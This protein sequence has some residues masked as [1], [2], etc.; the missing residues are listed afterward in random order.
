M[1][2]I[3][4][5][6]GNFETHES[7]KLKRLD[8]VSVPN[9][10]LDI[11]YRTLIDHPDGAA[12]FGA[13][14]VIIEVAST[15]KPRGSLMDGGLGLTA[16]HLGMKSGLP[17]ALF[18]A[19]IPRLTGIGWLEEIAD[20]PGEPAAK[21]GE[22][23]EA[24]ED[25]RENLRIHNRDITIQDNTEQLCASDDALLSDLPPALS[26]D[27]PPFE[28]LERPALFP[29]TGESL[30]PQKERREFRERQ[31]Q[32]FESWWEAYWLKKSR[33]RAREAFGRRV[34]TPERFQEIMT[35]T[36]AQSAEMLSREPQHRPH[37]AT[38][39]NGERWADEALEPAKAAAAAVGAVASGIQ[40]A[41]R[42][43]KERGGL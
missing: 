35:A 8:W 20:D 23:A 31:D 16:R 5:W 15:C 33:K 24:P 9:D 6:S 1:L 18:D 12:H 7:R 19:V 37:G 41:M 4:N 27:D 21:P 3:R 43:L 11:R 25:F 39:L 14:L 40:G 2:R 36:R 29:V 10:L 22:S 30:D 17:V 13:W 26:I 32:W 34:R 28:S 38:W 42:L